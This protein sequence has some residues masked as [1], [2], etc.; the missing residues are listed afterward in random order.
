VV[1]LDPPAFA[2]SREKRHNA[3]NAYKRLNALA[4]KKMKPGALLF[5]FSCSQVVDRSL[6]E[7]TIMA[8][9][10][11][12][13]RPVQILH[14]LSQGADHPINIF[15]AEGHYLKGLLLRIE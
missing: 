10:I 8:A 4:I 13:G 7:S 1:I 6:F 15:H 14:F 5:T 3:M 12:V 9:A 11:E 2:K